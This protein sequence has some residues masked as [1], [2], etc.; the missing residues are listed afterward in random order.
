M[1][2]RC[3][4]IVIAC[5]ALFVCAAQQARAQEESDL[6]RAPGR[7]VTLLSQVRYHDH[8]K[9]VFNFELGVRGDEDT[10]KKRVYDLRY[11]GISENGNEHWFDVPMCNGS[12]KKLKDL[13]ELKWADVTYVPAVFALPAPDCEGVAWR[14]EDGKVAEITPEGVN[15]RAVAGHMYVMRVK[16]D[17]AD[18][19]AMFRIESLGPEGE[20]VITWKRV[21]SPG[22]DLPAADSGK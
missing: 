18:F 2:R 15:V 3:S 17:K 16:D 1:K 9:S 4:R 19:Y 13:G 11:G 7:T 6:S 20:C 12:R 10:A 22:E 5:L 21:P 8:W 14:Y